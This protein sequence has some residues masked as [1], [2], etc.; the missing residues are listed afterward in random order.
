MKGHFFFSEYAWERDLHILSKQ[1][2]ASFRT[3]IT[4]QETM[5]T[6]CKIGVFS[7]NLNK[8]NIFTAISLSPKYPCLSRLILNIVRI[9]LHSLC[10]SSVTILRFKFL[11]CGST[12]VKLTFLLTSLVKFSREQRRNNFVK[13]LF[14]YLFYNKIKN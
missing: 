4:F 11:K 2:I 8:G 12:Y 13:M 5:F 7:L 3:E 14:T 6:L 1:K 10:T 9:A